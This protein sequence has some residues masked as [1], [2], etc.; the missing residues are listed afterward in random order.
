MSGTKILVV[1]LVLLV[2]LFVGFVVVG[3]RTNASANGPGSSPSDAQNFD[4]G[5]Y[6]LINTLGSALGAFGPKLSPSQLQPSAT[7]F[8]LQ[9]RPNFSIN[10]APD[11]SHNFRNAKFVMQPATANGCGHIIYDATGTPPTGLSSLKHQDPAA[12][13][14]ASSAAAASQVSLV[15]LAGGGTITIARGPGYSGACTIQLQ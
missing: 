7:T 14:K 12:N 3:A 2:A 4:P 15:I 9:A 1:V 11:A 10:V 8:S 13:R 5:N 6:P